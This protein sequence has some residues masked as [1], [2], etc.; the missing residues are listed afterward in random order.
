MVGHSL[1]ISWT[2]SGGFCAQE[3]KEVSYLRFALTEIK[4]YQESK[5]EG[6]SAVSAQC[7]KGKKEH[8]RQEVQILSFPQP[9]AW[10]LGCFT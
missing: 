10:L 5:V 8:K 2:V 3:R 6:K 1:P 7:Y 9:G 4:N